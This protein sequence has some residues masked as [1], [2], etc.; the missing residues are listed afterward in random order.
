MNRK[1]NSLEGRDYSRNA[2]NSSGLILVIVACL[3]GVVYLSYSI[4]LE[5]QRPAERRREAKV[6][7]RSPYSDAGT[8]F[9]TRSMPP[10]RLSQA[11]PSA[12]APVPNMQGEPSSEE[13]FEDDA[14]WE[15]EGDTARVP[16]PDLP[17]DFSDLESVA[18]IQDNFQAEMPAYTQQPLPQSSGAVP[19]VFVDGYAVQQVAYVTPQQSSG[20]AQSQPS[21]NPGSSGPAA[22]GGAAAGAAQVPAT[23]DADEF[24]KGMYLKEL[25]VWLGQTIT[26]VLEGG[27][28]AG[29]EYNLLKTET[30]GSGSLRFTDLTTNK[31]SGA[32][33]ESE[34]GTGVRWTLGMHRQLVGFRARYFDFRE[35]SFELGGYL[36]GN[37]WPRLESSQ[38]L[39]LTALDIELTQSYSLLGSALESSF[40]VRHASLEATNSILGIG[41]LGDSLEV[42]GSAYVFR[43]VEA[44]G[45]TFSIGGRSALPWGWGASAPTLDHH[46]SQSLCYC[47]SGWSWFWSLRGS[48]LWGDSMAKASTE[49]QTYVKYNDAIQGVARSSDS[50]IANLE[51]EAKLFHTELLLGLEYRHQLQILPAIMSFRTALEYQGWDT[52]SPVAESRSFAFLAST[53]PRF[54][55]RVDSY[56]TAD[57]RHFN[58]MGI[59][60]SVTFNY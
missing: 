27:V 28:Y 29:W 11:V 57:N 23:P 60:L 4:M 7:T 31:F 17:Q 51:A 3:V 21:N 2:R 38:R 10:S 59:N 32:D 15:M 8:R 55:G 36:P 1:A 24:G 52:G 47:G 30:A 48:L 53:E 5:V 49:A 41:S 25:G 34:F 20:A 12:Y 16:G 35:E 6:S 37:D 58:L 19:P 9:E 39:D 44:I 33:T 22:S 13:G 40:G 14:L 46:C 42:H 43:T 54:G 56:A 45:P 26:P 50:S 18:R